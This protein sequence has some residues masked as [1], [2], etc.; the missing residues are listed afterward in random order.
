VSIGGVWAYVSSSTSVSITVVSPSGVAGSVA[1]VLVGDRGGRSVTM[2]RAFRYDAAPATNTPDSNQPN[3]PQAPA[4]TGS[5][6]P[7]PTGPAPTSG[8]TAPQAP[9]PTVTAPSQPAASPGPAGATRR[10][11]P[12]FGPAVPGSGLRLAPITGGDPLAG[13]GSWSVWRCAGLRCS[14]VPVR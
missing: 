5:V 10:T 7:A 4:P 14:G 9:A 1:D 3:N 6:G 12:Q 2:P 8:P 13:M 11:L